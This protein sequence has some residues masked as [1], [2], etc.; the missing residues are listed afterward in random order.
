MEIKV[1]GTGCR[2]C[3]TLKEMVAEVIEELHIDAEVEEVKEI[4]KIVDYGVMVMP[5]LVVNGEVKASGKLPTREQIK[6]WLQ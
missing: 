4:D 5:A 2:K 3:K 6:S 1:L